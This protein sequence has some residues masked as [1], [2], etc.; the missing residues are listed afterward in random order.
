[1]PHR[2][3][4]RRAVLR[5]VRMTRVEKILESVRRVQRQRARIQIKLAPVHIA[6]KDR[7][8]THRPQHRITTVMDN[9][10]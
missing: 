8:G 2:I 1:M 6:V 10:I 4:V 3:N 5:A 7:F 9:R